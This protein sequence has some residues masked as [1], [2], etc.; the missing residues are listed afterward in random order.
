MGSSWEARSDPSCKQPTNTNRSFGFE[1]NRTSNLLWVRLSNQSKTI[2]LNPIRFRSECIS[3][4]LKIKKI[5][6]RRSNHSKPLLNGINR[7]KSS[8]KKYQTECQRS[9]ILTDNQDS[10]A[11]NRTID[12]I[13]R[14]IIERSNGV[15]LNKFIV[16]DCAIIIRRGTGRKMSLARRNITQYPLSTNAN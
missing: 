13:D 5:K 11:D 2:E 7:K 16:R 9:V 8:K 6:K 3:W 15:R 1:Q 10:P 14:S 4:R 12:C